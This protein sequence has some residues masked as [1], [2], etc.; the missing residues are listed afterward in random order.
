MSFT[1]QGPPLPRLAVYLCY[2]VLS[3]ISLTKVPTKMVD[4][5]CTN[6][7][8]TSKKL[9]FTCQNWKIGDLRIYHTEK[10]ECHDIVISSMDGFCMVVG[11]PIFGNAH[12]TVVPF[13]RFLSFQCRFLKKSNRIVF[14]HLLSCILTWPMAV[15]RIPMFHNRE[16]MYTWNLSMVMLNSQ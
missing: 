5:T 12:L 2:V 8:F 10:L 6:G 9:D 16:R 7:G 14:L 11:T 15:W 1:D 4:L 13:F 3:T